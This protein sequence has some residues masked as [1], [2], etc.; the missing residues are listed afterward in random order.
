MEQM[1]ATGVC[2]KQQLTARCAGQ[3]RRASCDPREPHGT[4]RLN[5]GF[6][7]WWFLCGAGTSWQV[8]GVPRGFLGDEPLDRS[9]RPGNHSLALRGYASP[10]VVSV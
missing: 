9:G 3:A 6:R 10:K 8:L 7:G 5:V 1:Q 2:R 4:L